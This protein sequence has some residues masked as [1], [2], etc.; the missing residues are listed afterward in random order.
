MIYL[1][2][3]K[4]GKL[5]K[6]DIFAT[7][8]YLDENGMLRHGLVLNYKQ[9][10]RKVE[11]IM[12]RWYNDGVMAGKNIEDY[13][14]HE[15]AH[16]MPFQNCVS[17]V[18]YIELNEKIRRQFIAGISEYADRSKDGRECLA[19]AFVRYRNGEWIPDEARKLIRKYILHWRRV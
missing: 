2:S 3:I 16:I 18:E 14:A 17:E 4:G 7:G 19:E 12:P 9:D 1:D 8:A 6:N 10:Y 5:K 11:T 13:I 15:M